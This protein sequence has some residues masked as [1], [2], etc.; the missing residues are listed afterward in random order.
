MK[1]DTPSG[2]L[3]IG[4]TLVTFVA[5]LRHPT[6][7]LSAGDNFAREAQY[8]VWVHGIVIATTVLL[9][10]GLLGL[11][12]RL[13]GGPDLATAG[14]TTYGFAVICVTIAAAVSGFAGTALAARYLAAEPDTRHVVHEMFH[15]NSMLN[16]AFAKMHLV[17]SAAAV[18]L[19][20]LAM[21]KTQGFPRGLGVF[22]IIVGLGTLGGL[23]LGSGHIGLH[24]LLLYFGG[25]GSWMIWAGILLL[26]ADEANTQ[27]TP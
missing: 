11:R 2:L 26:R 27:P 5:L 13:S 7:L 1:R 14:L 16:Q 3:L 12:R 24:A 22:G 19:W 15:Y 25:Q 4:G 20:S 18:L 6:G 10:L 21:L 23:A 8:A 17:A 9:F